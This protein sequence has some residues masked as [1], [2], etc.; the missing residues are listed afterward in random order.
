MRRHL[1]KTKFFLFYFKYLLYK[2]RRE[3]IE[4]YPIAEHKR[5]N[6]RRKKKFDLN[7]YARITTT[8]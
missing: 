5:K 6:T 4:M 2:K 3:S 1:K 7:D 8:L